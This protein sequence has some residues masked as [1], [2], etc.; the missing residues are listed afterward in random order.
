MRVPVFAPADAALALLLVSVLVLVAVRD[1]APMDPGSGR[2]NPNRANA[3]RLANVPGMDPA[4]GEAIV[5]FREDHGHFRRLSDLER[6]PEIGSKHLRNI[7]PYLTVE[8]ET[9]P[10]R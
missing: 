7:R 5:R 10:T 3:E 2:V 1:L 6:I 4:M 8:E 9:W